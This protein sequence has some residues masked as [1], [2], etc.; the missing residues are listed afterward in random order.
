VETNVPAGFPRIVPGQDSPTS[1]P[2]PLLR[3][4]RVCVLGVNY[5]A[6]ILEATPD[7]AMDVQALE[8]VKSVEP[9]P[10]E[11]EPDQ[12]G[13]N[14]YTAVVSTLYEWGAV[15]HAIEN[16]NAPDPVRA[17]L[18]E[19]AMYREK[20]LLWL[21]PLDRAAAET[22]GLDVTTHT[23]KVE[24]DMTAVAFV[25]KEDRDSWYERIDADLWGMDAAGS[26]KDA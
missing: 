1:E 16:L 19:P 4:R 13:S 9:D 25:R 15:V 3:V 21:N 20:D 24:G 18:E 12:T 17:L 22:L 10:T 11:A 5:P 7:G 14:I 6:L 26:R 23:A 2:L 8:C